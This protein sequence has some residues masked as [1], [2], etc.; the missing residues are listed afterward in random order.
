M[1]ILLR[2]FAILLL[3]TSAARAASPEFTP[4]VTQFTKGD[5]GAAN[6]NW[7]V[8][9]GPDG[10]IYIGNN[11]GLL[12]YDGVRW[13]LTPMPRGKIVRS[14]WVDPAGRIYI[15][16]FQEFGYFDRDAFGKLHYTSLSAG[17]TDYEWQN[18]EIWTIH[19]W[20]GGVVFQAFTSYFI[21]RG[22]GVEAVRADDIFMFFAP[23]G[24]RMFSH[25]NRCG[26]SVL[27][28]VSG[29]F[30]EVPGAPFR[31]PLIAVLPYDQGE[32]LFVSRSDGIFLF[33]GM[34]FTAFRT[35]ADRQIRADQV[36]RAAISRD[37]N[38]IVVGTILGGAVAL[39]RRGEKLWTVNTANVLQNNTVLGL[40][41]DAD[42]NLWMALDKGIALIPANPSVLHISSFNP[43]VGSV[44]TAAYRSPYLY[45]GTNQGLYR[46]T[47]SLLT[48]EMGPAQ[49]DPA[50]T[51]H[52]W[53]IG[54]YDGQLICGTNEATY[55]PGPGGTRRMA[56][57]EGGMCLAR[58][59]INRR[60]VL[61]QGTYTFITLYSRG[62]EGWEYSHHLTDFMN[63]IKYIE[64]DYTGVVWA[65]HL[66]S[67]LYA[68]RLSQDLSGIESITRFKSLD[69][70]NELPVG[71]FS[72]EG[73]VVFADGNRFYTYDDIQKEIIPYTEL[74]DALGTFVHAYRVCPAGGN[75]Y[76][77][78]TPGAAGLFAMG[79]DGA[80]QLDAVYYSWFGDRWLDNEQNAVTLSRN[81]SLLTL[82]NG[83]ALY[84]SERASGRAPEKDLMLRETH[85]MNPVSGEIT[86]LPLVPTEKVSLGYAFRN[87]AF[88]LCYPDYGIG[89]DMIFRYRLEGFDHVP[90]QPTSAPDKVYYNLPYGKYRFTA[91]L[92]TRNGVQLSELSYPFEIRPPL[93]LSKGA[94]AGYMALGLLLLYL[95]YL[96]IRLLIR[97]RNRKVLAEKEERIN[98]LERQNL[99]SE[100]RLKSKELAASTMELI[101]KNE[102]LITLRDELTA[103]KEALG[104]QYPAK[105]YRK[106]VGLIDKS[107]SSEDDWAMFQANFDRIHENFFRN[108]MDRYPSLTPNDLR[109]CAYLR[110][111]L[112]SKDIASLMNISLKG[113]EVARYRIRKKIGLPSDRSLTGFMIDFR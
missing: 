39:N 102:I 4:L 44:Y 32:W 76:W 71:V 98:A 104:T 36:N 45:L 5:Y 23:A 18:D 42:D 43:S 95:I 34:R 27:D 81:E 6:Q 79:P 113:V 90:Q 47:Y 72:I 7:A 101:K 40:F 62:P 91:T 50:I 13:E 86:A 16:S 77:F 8:G 82:E 93:W 60:D 100:V 1:K 83:L 33:D 59:R 110:L 97:R 11:N 94:K 20:D 58:G 2:L 19:P 66:H 25:T 37:G 57:V 15:G 65:G 63:P 87:V 38:T 28:P 106:L 55:S 9:Q 49:L 17:L 61:V 21:W 53:D 96:Y 48:R 54:L 89:S 88:S 68:L 74:N 78:I 51:G 64:V 46:A 26:V 99:E 30:R 73:R 29:A 14:L 92:S 12:S 69:G 103:Q 52:V 22:D 31:S 10:I 105:Y 107:L 70:R 84:T 80:E 67:G 111:N 3:G 35:G 85:A 75:R 108:L 112:T 24:G 56:P 109:F 41:F